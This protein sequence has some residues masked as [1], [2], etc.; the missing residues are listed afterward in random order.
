VAI[1]FVRGDMFAQPFDIRV[2]PVNCVG[3]MGAGV[4]LRFKNRYPAMYRDYQAKCRKGEIRPGEISVWKTS[5]EHVIN[6]PTKLHWRH[7]S[8]HEWI[9]EG[10]R[11]LHRYLLSQGSP[12][13][14]VPALGCGHGG[15]A[16]HRVSA[17]L[18]EHLK[19]LAAEVHAFFPADSRR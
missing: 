10:L 14:A 7:W 15:L 3:V 13:V 19:D 2:N 12:R 6:F 5:T 16:W 9:E 17:L 11:G 8:R 4:A 1:V 18:T